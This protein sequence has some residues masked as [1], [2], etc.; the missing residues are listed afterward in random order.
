MLQTQEHGALSC[1][2]MAFTLVFDRWAGS[3]SHTVTSPAVLL[4]SAPEI[5]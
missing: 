1:G 2:Q 3:K 4:I 5:M